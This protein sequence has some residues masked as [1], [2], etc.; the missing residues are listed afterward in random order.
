MI[1]KILSFV[2]TVGMV[3]I[4]FG[5]ITPQVVS[6]ANLT[7]MS[8]VVSNLTASAVANHTITFTT[9]TGLASGATLILTFDNSTSIDAALTYADV[10]FRYASTDVTLA[11]APSGATMGVVRTS[12]TV[13]TFTNGTTV[14]AGGSV[15]VIKIGTNTTIGGTGTHQITNG[16]AGTTLL[17]VS[18]TFGDTGA[19]SM[20]IISNSIVAVSAEVLSSLSF[21]VSSNAIY[22]G[23][24]RTAGA[25]FAQNTNPGYVTCPTTTETEAF[26]MT[27]GTNATA[28]YTISVQGDTLTSGANT[29]TAL[30]SNTA[31]SPGSEQFGLRA[32]ATGGGG[33]V[34]APYAAAGYAYTGTTSTPATV[35]TAS[36]PS[37]TTTYSVRYLANISAVTEA[38]SYSTSHTYVATGNF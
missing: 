4:N 2:L 33:A 34:Q 37:A 9:P 17:R 22:F 15:I 26:N 19:M 35:A 5:F 29:I 28:G 14:I 31:S 20:S 11:A 8:D 10:D 3:V 36:A 18:G 30:A 23:N 24:L 7:S 25:C 21:T 12:A 32:T 13:L 38:G 1:K 27:A 6:A 16:T